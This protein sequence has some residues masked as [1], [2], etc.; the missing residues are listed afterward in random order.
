MQLSRLSLKEKRLSL[1]FVFVYGV[2]SVAN[3]AEALSLLISLN[4][5]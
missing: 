1:L 3:D 5:I 4:S 2:R